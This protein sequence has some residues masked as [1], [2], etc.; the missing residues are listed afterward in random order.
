M[1]TFTQ[2]DSIDFIYIMIIK[3]LFPISIFLPIYLTASNLRQ[4]Q[5]M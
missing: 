3:N 1:S 4:N 2:M 5:I